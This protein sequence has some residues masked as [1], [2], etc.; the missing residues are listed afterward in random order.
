[1]FIVQLIIGFVFS[2]LK[3]F[4]SVMFYCERNYKE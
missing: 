4:L 2:G 1:M 3:W